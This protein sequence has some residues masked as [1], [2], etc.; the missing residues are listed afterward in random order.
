MKSFLKKPVQIALSAMKVNNVIFGKNRGFKLRYNDSLNLDMVLGLHEP[1]TF[2]VF[3]LFVKEGMTV[4]DIGANVGYFTRFLSKKVGTSGYV[5]SFEPIPG[6][7]ANLRET[8]DL[9]K[10]NNVIPINKAVSNATGTEKIFLSNTHYM[11]SLDSNWA[12]EDGGAI[13]VPTIT[14][15][16]YFEALGR[17][18]DFIKMDI[19]GGGVYALRGMINCITK[20]EPVLLLES[21]TSAE[22]LAIG[23]ALSLIPYDIYRVGNPS[24][25]KFL[26]RDFNDEY[27]VYGTVVAIP[28]SKA[29]LFGNWS[30][31]QFQKRRVG[32][33]A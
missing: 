15:D 23:K 2:E 16:S 1:N 17:Y 5:H 21:H 13:N 9:N 29:H 12:S 32:Q 19:E 11:A 7:F 4:A 31:A 3:D 18:P 20:N 33:R 25:V 6:T 24:P 30:P 8:I 14:L 27:G 22:D 26:D 10:L 28:R